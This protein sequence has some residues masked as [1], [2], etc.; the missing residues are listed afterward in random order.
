MKISQLSRDSS[1]NTSDYVVGDQ[2]SGPSTQRF[3]FS[4][5]IAL[6]WLLANIPSGNT[7]P[8]TRDNESQY[9]FVASG[10]LWT[11]D[12]P[13]SNRNA[14][15]TAGVCYING[16]RISI[17]AV[18]G[19]TF[20][21]SDDTY[22]D[23][24]DNGDGTGTVVYTTVSNNATSPSL[25]A[26]SIRIAIIVAG[27]GNIANSG[28]IN[29]GQETM[30]LPIASSIPYSITDSIGNLICCRDPNHKILGYRQIITAFTTNATASTQVTGLSCPVIVPT[31]RKIKITSFAPNCTTTSGAADVLSIGTWDGTVG[32]GTDLIDG[33]ITALN[34]GYTNFDMQTTVI[35]TPASGSKTYN[36]GFLG[37]ASANHSINGASVRPTYILVEL[38]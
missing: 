36:L 31:G 6:F 38:E 37:S 35:T 21:A 23:V 28:S 27:S 13:G 9:A 29:Q 26:N 30:V 19:R 20:T 14:S 10:L 1:P 2:A 25:A 12:S 34:A 18:T 5:L 11:A 4:D 16:R 8:I 33:H 3:V 24:L 22:V 32:S 17:A 7:S 15:M